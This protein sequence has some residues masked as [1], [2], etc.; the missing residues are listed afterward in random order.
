MRNVAQYRIVIL[1]AAVFGLAA[2]G[3]ASPQANI[4]VP[5]PAASVTL[6]G[7]GGG[8]TILT[9]VIAPF[10]S[11]A[12]ALKLDFLQ[13][14]GSSAAKK[15]V[16]EGGLD[17][18]ILLSTDIAG[19]RKDGLDLLAIAEDPVAFIVHGDLGVKSLTTAQLRGIYLGQITNWSEVGGPDAEIIVLARDEDEGATKVL[20]KA[21]FGDEPWA[22]ATI[23]FTKAGELIDAVKS[24]PNSIGFG[25]Y[26][27]FTISGLSVDTITVDGVHPRDYA[28][29]GY[30]FP[31]RTLALMYAPA[32]QKT[33]QPLLDYLKGD[34]AR[35]AM[36]QAEVVPLP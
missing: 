4:L 16:L 34:A 20:R 25:S 23:V 33:L 28:A 32:S 30:A 2:C 7:S 12:P 24:T 22:A 29:G 21:L 1:L 11:S 36:L 3:I 13:G 19:E 35:S 26:S 15:A 17:V 6:G 9:Y 10:Q 14:S 5:A 8:T 18:A 27:G 31:A